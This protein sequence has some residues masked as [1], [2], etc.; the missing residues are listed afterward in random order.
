[1]HENTQIK[2]DVLYL[3]GARINKCAHVA[4]YLGVSRQRIHQILV[5]LE[6]LGWMFRGDEKKHGVWKITPRGLKALFRAQQQ[7]WKVSENVG[8][9]AG[10]VKA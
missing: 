8:D 9:D 6:E 3:M 2:F 5:I 1:M 7:G 10:K 4:K